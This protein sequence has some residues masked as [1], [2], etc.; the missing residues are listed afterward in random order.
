MLWTDDILV[1]GLKRREAG[2]IEHA[3]RL[4]A[5]K[6][7][8]YAYLQLGNPEAAEDLAS[9]VMT[10]MLEKIDGYRYVGVPLQV[11]LFQIARNLV[12]D[13]FRDR[14]KAAISLDTWLEWSDGAKASEGLEPGEHDIQLEMFADRELIRALLSELTDEQR[15]VIILRVVEGWQPSEIARMLNRT[16]DSVKSLQYRAIQSMRRNLERKGDPLQLENN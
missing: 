14:R 5:P 1:A 9:E 15:Q 3:V 7:Y 8:R 16:I 10:R 6:L 13:A 12:A 4:Y 2:A 11:W